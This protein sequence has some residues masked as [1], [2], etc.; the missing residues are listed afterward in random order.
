[1]VLGA[2]CTLFSSS[3]PSGG[4]Q[5]STPRRLP[6]PNS[7]EASSSSLRWQHGMCRQ[8]RAERHQRRHAA[9]P[10]HQRPRPSAAASA[11]PPQRRPT[12]L[13]DRS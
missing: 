6:L 9:P 12:A 4:I 11:P 2:L 13:T 5:Y 3:V 8:G 7:S 1:M 10:Q